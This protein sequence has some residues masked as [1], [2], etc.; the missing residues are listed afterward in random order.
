MR[1]TSVVFR[2]EGNEKVGTG[3]VM[4]CLS[5]ARALEKLTNVKLLFIVNEQ[6]KIIEKVA[7]RGRNVITV[8]SNLDEDHRRNFLA[9]V[10][11]KFDADLMIVDLP[12]SKITDF[13]DI[14]HIVKAV[15]YINELSKFPEY[16]IL[17]EDFELVHQKEKAVRKEG[18]K[19]LVTFGGSDPHGLTLK[20]VKAL[21]D[22]ENSIEISVVLGPLFAHY[23]YLKRL[24]PTSKRDF[25][26]IFDP[27]NIAELFFDA[28]VLITAGGG[29]CFEAA[30]VGTP[31]LILCQAKHQIE[32][33]S[34]LEKYGISINLGWGKDVPENLI[35]ST[36]RSL[37][38]N[39][40]LRQDMSVKGKK[41]ID[42]NG[43]ERVAK[44][45]LQR[46]GIK[47]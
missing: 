37:L 10:L 5:L 27:E 25:T 24:L 28:D 12:D 4:R 21:K 18:K 8:P 44:L 7:K 22:L 32:N 38:K 3:H 2:T 36:L 29:S 17:N 16:L 43:A 35:F 31:S 13:K 1:K 26:L 20:T 45:I 33:A 15:V 6:E 11:K 42:G 40:Q 46:I 19:V 23:D 30:C 47:T 34:I 9:T 39:K 41:L 14:E